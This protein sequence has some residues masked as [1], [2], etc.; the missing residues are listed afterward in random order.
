[1]AA[2]GALL[3]LCAAGPGMLLLLRKRWA[4]ERLL[5]GKKS[6]G[7]EENLYEVTG[8]HRGDIMGMW[9]GHGDTEIRGHRGD[10]GTSLGGLGAA[11]T[12]SSVAA[13]THLVAMGT[14]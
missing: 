5:Q 8:G 9:E 3:L 6:L 12:R 13:G 1:M 4:N 14:H 7:E 11:G 2:E 10:T